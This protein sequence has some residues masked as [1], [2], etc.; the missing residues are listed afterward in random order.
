MISAFSSWADDYTIALV[1]PDSRV[2]PSGQITWEVGTFENDITEDIGHTAACIDELAETEGLTFT[3]DGWFAAG[4]SGGGSSAP[5]Y[6]THDDRFLAYGSL[7][8]G[9]FPEGMGDNMAQGWFSTGEDDTART[10]AGVVNDAQAVADAGYP[11][12]EVRVYPGGH[13]MS[14]TELD[15]FVAW[16]AAE[17]A[18]AA[19]PGAAKERG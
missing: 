10:P 3:D 4:F 16:W 1:A 12:P 19:Q 18:E 8:G 5:Y 6:G 7:H 14:D 9:A 13:N 11:E 15:E 17:A 2:S